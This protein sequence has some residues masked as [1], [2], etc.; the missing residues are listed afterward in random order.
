MTEPREELWDLENLRA[1]RRLGDWMYEQFEPYVGPTTVEVGAGIG[2]F[3]ER[4]ARHPAV[5]DLLLVEPEPLCAEVLAR[6]FENDPRVTVSREML[7][8]SRA[9]D[10][11]AG[12][13]DFLLC[14]NVLEHIYEEAPAMAAMAS[15][16]RPGGRLTV[17][18]PAHPRL[19]GR[20][21]RL[22]GHHR[23]YTREH[24]RDVVLSA[25]LEIDELYS[26]NLLGVP[27]WW[28]NRFRRSPQISR[29][30][31]RVYELLLSLWQPIERVRRPPWG[32]SLI[33]QAR[34]PPR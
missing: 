21:D 4:L 27:G 12:R 11:R 14:Q 10:E 29:R 23:R 30:A 16:L 9:L 25:G 31:L 3:S 18:V 17:L 24:L 5:R 26:F 15:A 19:Y 33:V 28:V 6:E 32:L 34:Q 1:A 2:T 8:H 22:Y 7:P 13:T 20:L